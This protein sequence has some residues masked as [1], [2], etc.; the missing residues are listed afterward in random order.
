M[1][2]LDLVELGDLLL[3]WRLYAGV[4]LTAGLIW[5]VLLFVPGEALRWAMCVP[6]GVVGVI[7]S[8]RWQIRADLGK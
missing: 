8:F 1:A 2:L 5:L 7:L 3:S 4:A 6:L